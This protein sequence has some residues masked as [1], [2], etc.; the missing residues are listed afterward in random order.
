MYDTI[1]SFRYIYNHFRRFKFEIFPGK[2]APGPPSWLTLSH[3]VTIQFKH[4]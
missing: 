1:V 4:N 3:C 2:H